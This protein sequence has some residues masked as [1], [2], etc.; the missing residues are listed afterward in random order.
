MKKGKLIVMS[1]IPG[2]G[3]SYIARQLLKKDKTNTTIIVNRDNIRNM[4]GEYWVPSRESLVSEIED[5]MI[6]TGLY[7][8]YSVIV[9][10]TNLNP[11]TIRKLEGLAEDYEVEIEFEIIKVSVTQAFTQILWRRLFGGRYISLKVVKNFYN[12]YKD[13]IGV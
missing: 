11:K 4:L 2:S 9:D 1:G 8:N 10:A 13:I 5:D 7:F 6:K 3:K 12:R